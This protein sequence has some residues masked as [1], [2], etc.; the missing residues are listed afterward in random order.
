MSGIVLRL[1]VVALSI[2][3]LLTRPPL[4]VAADTNPVSRV[5]HTANSLSHCSL[6]VTKQKYKSMRTGN[7]Y[8]LTS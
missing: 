2:H 6:D 7:H 5:T 1:L 4:L 8:A 3:F